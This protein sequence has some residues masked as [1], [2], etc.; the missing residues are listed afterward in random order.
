MYRTPFSEALK[1]KFIVLDGPDGA[2]KS[3]QVALLADAIEKAGTA[4]AVWRD[5]GGTAIGDKIRAILLDEANTTMTVR[6]EALLYMASRAQLYAERIA[7]ALAEGKC[8]LCDRWLSST[9]AYQ[10]VAG[11]IGAAA[12]L[13]IAQAALERTWPDLTVIIDLPCELGLQRSGPRPDRMEQKALDYH[14][15]VREAFVELGRCGSIEGKIA[16]VDGG[17][18]REE[19]HQGVLEALNNS[20]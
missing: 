5:P 14:R 17:G 8:V 18:S 15:R 9:V 6:C 11:N 16:V 7:P 4:V 3:T 12:V 20:F 1:G 10:A 19:V 2:G 13:Q